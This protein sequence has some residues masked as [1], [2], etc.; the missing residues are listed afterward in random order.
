VLQREEFYTK[1][2]FDS[3]AIDFHKARVPEQ[4]AEI[5][6]VLA[7]GNMAMSTMLIGVIQAGIDRVDYDD[8]E[9]RL[10]K[11]SVYRRCALTN[12]SGAQPYCLL[13]A[14]LLGIDDE[15]QQYRMHRTFGRCTDHA[16]DKGLLS[17]I[18]KYKLNKQHG[19]SR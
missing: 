13:M 16:N 8:L 15:L 3:D 5:G 6:C 11:A 1:A 9:V 14:P 12:D 2:L 4:I 7:R 19:P 18:E 17:S 10:C